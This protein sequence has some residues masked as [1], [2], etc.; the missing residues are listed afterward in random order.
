MSPLRSQHVRHVAVDGGIDGPT[1]F[2]HVTGVPVRHA[3]RRQR[4]GKGKVV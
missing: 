2:G 1:G 3:P 4:E